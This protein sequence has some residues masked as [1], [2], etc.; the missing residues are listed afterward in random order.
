MERE[1]LNAERSESKRRKGAN[2]A[3][4]AKVSMKELER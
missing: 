2:E 1:M 4:V 3:A